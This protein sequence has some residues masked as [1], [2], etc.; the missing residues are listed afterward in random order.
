MTTTSHIVGVELLPLTLRQDARGRVL[1][2]W[3]RDDPKVCSWKIEEVYLST[4]NS[5]AVKAWHRHKRMTL[6]Y[7]CVNGAVRVGMYDDRPGSVTEGSSMTVLL[8]DGG[9]PLH[10]GFSVL[11]IPPMVWNGFCSSLPDKPATI[12]NLPNQAHDPD[13]IERIHPRDFPAL[14]GFWGLYEVAG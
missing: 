9:S 12:L 10:Y 3:R 11:V 2:V 13:E 7:V 14:P 5:K 4:I 1:K 8:S 6:R